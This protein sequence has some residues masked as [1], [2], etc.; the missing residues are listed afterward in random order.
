MTFFITI[1]FATSNV[2]INT[3][4]LAAEVYYGAG[5]NISVNEPGTEALSKSEMVV[6]HLLKKARLLDKWYVVT[7][8]N[9]YTSI[10]LAEYLYSRKT[11]MRGTINK[12]RGIPKALQEKKLPNL[13]IAYMVKGDHLLAIKFSDRKDVYVLSTVDDAGV[14][15]KTRHFRGEREQQNYNRPEAIEKYNLQM[16]GVD[17]TDQYLA[18]RSIVRKSFVWF[19]K[20]GMHYLQRLLLNAFIRYRFEQAP[21]RPSFLKFT[22]VAIVLFTGLSSEPTKRRRISVELEGGALA[23]GEM[24]FPEKIPGNDAGRSRLKCRQCAKTG[25]R[26]D[27]TFWCRGCPLKPALCLTCFSDWHTVGDV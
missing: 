27:T 23:A 19:K 26:K 16:G 21:A 7:L 18:P 1:C 25:S 2:T 13:G 3:R 17:V 15:Q 14:V 5:T 20:V 10:R 9:W 24:H 12:N 8:D 11:F 6:V 22:K 4:N